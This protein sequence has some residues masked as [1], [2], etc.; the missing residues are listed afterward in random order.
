MKNTLLVIG[1][2]VFDMGVRKKWKPKTGQKYW[3]IDFFGGFLELN[4]YTWSDSLD[5]ENALR[6]GLVFRTKAEVAEAR[7]KIR[8]V[9]GSEYAK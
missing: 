2:L 7:R 8:K 4:R 3:T 6:E 1:V 9:L 5:D